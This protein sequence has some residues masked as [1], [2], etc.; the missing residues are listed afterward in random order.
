MNDALGFQCDGRYAPCPNNYLPPCPESE[1]AACKAPKV[2]DET[3]C[4]CKCMENNPE[5]IRECLGQFDVFNTETCQCEL[6]CPKYA[7]T[8][9]ECAIFG[10]EWRECNCYESLNNCCLANPGLFFD[11]LICHFMYNI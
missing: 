1:K 5:G 10:M 9:E 3:T 4:Q 6:Q 7:P 2:W 8:P 11:H